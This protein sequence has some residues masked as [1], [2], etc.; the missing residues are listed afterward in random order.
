VEGEVRGKTGYVPQEDV[1][2]PALRAARVLH[3]AA[4][5]R[6][7][8][9]TTARERK[10]II[11]DITDRLELTPHA[12]VRVE[13]LSG[14][15][16]KRLSL[17]MELI[18]EPSVLF[19]DEPTSGLDPGLEKKFMELFR[20][21]CREGRTIIVT[22]HVMEHVDLLD[23]IFLIYRGHLVYAGPP[24]GA[25]SYFSVNEHTDIYRRLEDLEPTKWKER[26]EQTLFY[27]QYVEGRLARP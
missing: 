24:G 27:Q 8:K 11:R 7:P 25:L 4:L 18:T 12:G 21:L 14:G 22:T 15:Q 23:I 5:L 6:L 13:Q 10:R 2:P 9:R 26:F 20:S 1:L 16:R 3:F 19:L 17:A